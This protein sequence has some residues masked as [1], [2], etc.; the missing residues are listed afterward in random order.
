MRLVCPKCSAAYAIEDRLIGASG[1]RA[2]CPRCKHQ[3]FVRKG[4]RRE[5]DPPVAEPA[6][7]VIRRGDKPVA[8]A[9]PPPPR[10]PPLPG[11]RPPAHDP[12]AVPTCSGCGKPLQDAFDQALGACDSCRNGPPAADF[13]DLL[14][15][16]GALQLDTSAP[17]AAAPAAPAS[18]KRGS[19]TAPDPFDFGAT[20]EFERREVAA[21]PVAE[22]AFHWDAPLQTQEPVAGGPANDGDPEPAAERVAPA[23]VRAPRVARP[24]QG[25]TGQDEIALRSSPLKLVESRPNHWRLIAAG[26]GGLLLSVV[27]AL[28][29]WP[30]WHGSTPE[31][32]PQTIPPAVTAVL[33]RWRLLFVEVSGTA[34]S[35]LEQGRA[36]LAA[37]EPLAYGEAEEAFQQ[38]L[39]LEPRSDEAITGYVQAVALGRKSELDDDTYAEAEALILASQRRTARS[40]PTLTAH[41][42][43]LLTRPLVPGNL[44][45]ARA[46]A[47]EAVERSTPETRA[48][49]LLAQGRSYLQSSAG[50]AAQAFSEALSGLRPP[51]SAYFYRAL[52]LEAQG[53]YRGAIEDLRRRLELTPGQAD[54]LEALGRIYQECGDVDRARTAYARAREK[55]PED[56]RFAVLHLAFAYQVDNDPRLAAAGLRALLEDADRYDPRVAGLGLVHLATVERLL[57]HLSASDAAAHKA[58]RYKADATGASLQLFLNALARGEAASARTAFSSLAG[59][60][61]QPGLEAVLEGQ[62][63][64]AEGQPARAAE[65]CRAG[66]EKDPRR[67]DALICSGVARVKAGQADEGYRALHQAAQLEPMR[68]APRPAVTRLFVR[69]AD[70]LTPFTG[71]LTRPGAPIGDVRAAIHEGILRFR[72][73]E[74]R[75]AEGLLQNALA[76]DASNPLAAAYLALISVARGDAA[77]AIRHGQQAAQQGRRIGVARYA[78]GEALALVGKRDLA[79]REFAD[80]IEAAPGLLAA[81]VSLARLEG[82]RG[83]KDA[84]RNRLT[85]AIGRDPSYLPAKRALY[86]L[87]GGG[88][89]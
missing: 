47:E 76:E 41:A 35:A 61:G 15:D 89:P 29:L 8:R 24:E 40:A 32:D 11:S 71:L 1:V 56:L 59:R 31:E 36:R 49:A 51:L 28:L 18:G 48:D 70:L 46:L 20:P 68:S 16:S 80:A 58:L 53:E 5:A 23:V 22:G 50:L 14:L 66:F 33:P 54:A 88:G 38:A 57:G 25:R 3:E 74:L 87:Q 6:V 42:N 13:Q 30:R 85:R 77:G 37:D 4:D 79:E 7:A 83:G 44:E 34:A 12:E 52:A 17:P 55:Y 45:Q 72:L 60:T 78:H 27:V 82:A 26:V 21:P 2:Q 73:G 10:P 67:V 69:E 86:A 63:L 39:L 9:A 43:L 75:E 19:P 62:L 81:E 65:V 84:A 64:M